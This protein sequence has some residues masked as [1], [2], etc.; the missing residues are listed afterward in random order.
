MT[1]LDRKSLVSWMGQSLA[2]EVQ[3]NSQTCIPQL[4]AVGYTVTRYKFPADSGRKVYLARMIASLFK[5]EQNIL[6]YLQNVGVFPSSSHRPLLYRLREAWGE[7]RNVE[8]FPG[9][10]FAAAEID[11]V[12]SLLI[13]AY[14]F[15]WDCF[16]IGEGGSLAV[17]IS[18]DEYYDLIY[19]DEAGIADFKWKLETWNS[20]TA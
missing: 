4:Q 2:I 1:S 6:V 15:F 5:V 20:K 18:H 13:L 8:E 11:D 9:H 3:F 14:E 12:A 10:L 19:L 16:I 17:Y 7:R